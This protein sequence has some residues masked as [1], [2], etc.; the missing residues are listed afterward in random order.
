MDVAAAAELV[1]DVLCS[2]FRPHQ[3]IEVLEPILASHPALTEPAVIT[4]G[5]QLARAYLLALQDAEAATMADRVMGPAERYELIPTIVD[6]L[7][8]RGTAL[9]N[10]GRMHEAIA[11]LE[12]ASTIAGDYDL[13]TPQMRATNNM[14]HLLAYQD[15]GGAMKACRTGMELADRLGD[16]RF[17]GAF[18]WAVAAYLDRDGRYEDA[19][20]LR[21]DIRDRYELPPSS[22][23]WYELTDL[24]IRVERG[25]IKAIDA[26]YDVVRR[27]VDDANPQSQ[28]AV[29]L[30]RA[31]L[32]LLTGHIVDAYDAV[33]SVEAAHRSPEHFALATVA[34]AMLRDVGRLEDVAAGV[35]SCSAHGRM[36][37]SVASALSGA[38]AAIRGHTDEATARFSDALA[39]DYLRLDRA[40]LQALFATLVGRGVPEARKASNAAFETFTEVGASAY[41]DLYSAGLPSAEDTQAAGG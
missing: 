31:K 24:I 40:S 41:L 28:A 3:A 30:A 33:S 27:A 34:A 21:N 36:L 12:G 14:G 4:A 13:P 29:P 38:R 20:A 37:A 35:A 19:Q 17:V 6:T 1:G 7:I 2:A 25:D 8:T 15:H 16:V 18:T 9:G 39:F 10:V 11:L 26:A 22:L 23:L 5:S 32:D